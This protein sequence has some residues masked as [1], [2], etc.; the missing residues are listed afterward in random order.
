MTTDELITLMELLRKYES[1]KVDPLLKRNPE[2]KIE[3]MA[4]FE[5]KEHKKVICEMYDLIAYDL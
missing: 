4:T 5:A 3:L 1:E 2:T